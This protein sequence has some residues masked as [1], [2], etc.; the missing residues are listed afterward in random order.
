MRFALLI[1]LI[2]F[3]GITKGQQLLFENYTSEQ[4]LS[5]NSCYTIAQDADGFM[6]FG[7]QDGLNRYDGKEFRIFLPQNA[8]GHKLPS[9]YISS[10]YFDSLQNQLWVGTIQGA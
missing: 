9:N 4:G 10:L 5:Q 8:D 1:I 3:S 6:W 7:T 2:M